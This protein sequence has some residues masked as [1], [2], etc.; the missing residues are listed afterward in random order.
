MSGPHKL[1]VFGTLISAFLI[2]S[3]WLYTHLPFPANCTDEI[4]AGRAVW[5]QYNCAACHQV[6]GLGGYLGP[7]L[8]NIYSRRG[9]NFLQGYLKSGNQVMPDFHLTDSQ[10]HHLLAWFQQMD[11]SGHA[12]PNTYH[13]Q[14]NGTLQP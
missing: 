7:D 14:F 2:Y 3:C 10:I 9:T 1:I 6:Y 11:Q 5:Q 4:S 12:D 8:T 13:I